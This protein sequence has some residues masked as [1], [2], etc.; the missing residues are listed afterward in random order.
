MNE[1]HKESQ[2]KSQKE[3]RDNSGQMFEEIPGETS[4]EFRHDI[5]DGILAVTQEKFLKKFKEKSLK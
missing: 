1:F 2:R 5:P 4:E 3:S